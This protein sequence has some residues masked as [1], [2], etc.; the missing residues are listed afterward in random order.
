M[1]YSA[2]SSIKSYMIG[3]ISSLLLL[4]FKNSTATFYGLFFFV[5]IQMQLIEYFLWNNQSCNWTNRFV[6]K[7]IPIEL[8]LQVFIL[9][10]GAYLTNATIIPKIYTY[11]GSIITFIG[12]ILIAIKEFLSYGH[13]TMANKSGSLKWDISDY[14]NFGLPYFGTFLIVL[15][16]LKQYQIAI[17]IFLLGMLNRLYYVF[18]YNSTWES[19]WCYFSAYIPFFLVIY[20]LLKKTI[21]M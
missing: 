16:S 12:V 19:R 15:L 17:P 9:Y 3:G 6:S 8:A 14:N 1:C 7:F 10:L 11:W 2:E 21:S 18:Y 4:T 13:C 5:V 20:F